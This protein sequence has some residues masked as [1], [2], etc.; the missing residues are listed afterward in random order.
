[1]KEIK[2]MR[3]HKRAARERIL[4][5]EIHNFAIARGLVMQF[6]IDAFY[7]GI[8]KPKKRRP[9]RKHIH[10]H[11]TRCGHADEIERRLCC[12]NKVHLRSTFHLADA[13]T[14]AISLA[15]RGV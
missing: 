5:D 9:F 13:W 1:M 11:R 8:M 14:A 7:N 4:L 12:R 3:C 6:E 15:L 10:D 2:L